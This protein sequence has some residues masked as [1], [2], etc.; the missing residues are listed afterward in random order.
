MTKLLITFGVYK[1]IFKNDL[2]FPLL[3]LKMNN[4][5]Y[6]QSPTEEPILT[7]NLI[8]DIAIGSAI[9]VGAIIVFIVW[10][11]KTRKRIIDTVDY[12]M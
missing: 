9:V 11:I 10:R 6:T 3:N 4:T 7:T 5:N 1:F 2:Y 8:V 12:Y